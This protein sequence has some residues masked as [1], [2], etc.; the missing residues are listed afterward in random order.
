MGYLMEEKI[1]ETCYYLTSTSWNYVLSVVLL[2]EPDNCQKP[3]SCNL[4][5]ENLKIES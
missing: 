2:V 3:I 5:I 1:G 4:K